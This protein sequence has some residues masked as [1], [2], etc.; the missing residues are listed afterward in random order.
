MHQ[1][2][3]TPGELFSVVLCTFISEFHEAQI[4]PRD[5]TLLL[6]RPTHIRSSHSDVKTIGGKQ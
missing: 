4:L 6:C 1:V 3:S 5:K 2:L